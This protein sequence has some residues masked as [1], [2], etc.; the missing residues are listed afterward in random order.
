LGDDFGFLASYTPE[1]VS[2]EPGDFTVEEVAYFDDGPTC[3][4]PENANVLVGLY[5]PEM[6]NG[7]VDVNGV[8]VYDG[9]NISQLGTG[10]VED[11][12]GNCAVWGINYNTTTNKTLIVGDFGGASGVA[13][14]DVIVW[15][16]NTSQ[17]EA[18]TING[19]PGIPYAF[20]YVS[21]EHGVLACEFGTNGE[22]VLEWDGNNTLSMVGDAVYGLN[23]NCVAKDLATNDYYILLNQNTIMKW[24]A[25]R[26]WET[27][28]NTGDGDFYG[29][30]IYNRVLYACGDGLVETGYNSINDEDVLGL[31]GLLRID[32]ASGDMASFGEMFADFGY[33]NEA[34]GNRMRVTEDGVLYL[35]GSFSEI[36]HN[37]ITVVSGSLQKY[38]IANDTWSEVVGA[39]MSNDY[40]YCPDVID[41]AFVG[42]DVYFSVW[43][44]GYIDGVATEYGADYA[45]LLIRLAN[46]L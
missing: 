12:S 41:V 11:G 27:I 16:G 18:V 22:A 15:N 17:Y 36:S 6:V 19:L 20:Q 40:D 5:T 45:S 1:A 2:E 23:I 46:A 35:A 8:M 43:D 31:A 25:A 29:M 3:L 42:N 38:D 26:G 13:S 34:Y 39:G 33:G 4:E 30:T 14:E 28:F 21:I 24:D 44:V 37:G 10:L 7:E 32:L 9:A